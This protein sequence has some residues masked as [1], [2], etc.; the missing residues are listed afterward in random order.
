MGKIIQIEKAT[1]NENDKLPDNFEL[2][3]NYPNPF[4]PTTL[5]QYSLPENVFVTLKVFDMLGRE[6]AVLVNAYQEA[7][8]KSVEFDAKDLPSGI[9]I[10][11]ISAGKFISAK[12]MILIR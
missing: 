9:Y 3:N 12:K 7:G 10:Y 5:I 4:N 11:K 6:V 2:G 8:Y 1:T